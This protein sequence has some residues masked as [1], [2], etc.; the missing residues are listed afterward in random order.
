MKQVADHNRF[1][2]TFD[3]YLQTLQVGSEIERDDEQ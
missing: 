2:V 1:D 3:T